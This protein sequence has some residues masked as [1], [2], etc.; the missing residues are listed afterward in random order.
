MAVTRNGSAA[1]SRNPPVIR[2]L[3]LQSPPYTSRGTVRM[4]TTSAA[5][6]R[7]GGA[8]MKSAAKS[9]LPVVGL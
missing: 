3:L 9:R 7:G 5:V 2:F 4:Q 6:S 8:E 1:N